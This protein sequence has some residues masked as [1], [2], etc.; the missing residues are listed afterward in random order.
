MAM[1]LYSGYNKKLQITHRNDILKISIPV[2]KTFIFEDTIESFLVIYS[3][4]QDRKIN[5]DNKR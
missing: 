1:T 2:K 5:T 4:N 3:Y